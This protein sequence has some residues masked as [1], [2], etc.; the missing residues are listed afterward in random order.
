MNVLVVLLGIRFKRQIVYLIPVLI[1]FA[2]LLIIVEA[3]L[4]EP[5]DEMNEEDQ[6]I[7][8]KTLARLSFNFALCALL[9]SPSFLF[10]GLYYLPTMVACLWCYFEG[11]QSSLNADQFI[12]AILNQ[13]MAVIVFIILQ[14]REL[15]R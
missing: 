8:N 7:V 4:Y 13:V 3:S 2:Q 6:R 15:K 12:I 5:S 10:I 1:A 11:S 14:K 9:L